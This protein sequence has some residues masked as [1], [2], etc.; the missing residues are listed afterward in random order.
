MMEPQR[1]V[2]ASSAI[3]PFKTG[4]TVTVSP[5]TDYILDAFGNA[6]RVERGAPGAGAMGGGKATIQQ[7]FDHIGNLLETTDG[8]Q[9]TTVQ[10]G[11]TRYEYDVAGRVSKEYLVG[12]A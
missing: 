6:V 1:A 9:G 2:V 3:D 10:A 11:I 4:G 12:E 7:K 5:V 8:L